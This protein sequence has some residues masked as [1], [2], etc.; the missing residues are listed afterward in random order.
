MQIC[1]YTYWMASDTPVQKSKVHNS[2]CI[3][4]PFGE[5]PEKNTFWAKG[6]AAV[7]S[8]GGAGKLGEGAERK[9]LFAA[10]HLDSDLFFTMCMYYHL[11]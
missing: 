2:V 4:A 8:A 6:L 3:N 5:N 10:S 11:I 9:L 7:I 1:T